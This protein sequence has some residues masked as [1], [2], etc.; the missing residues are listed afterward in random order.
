MFK[1][2]LVEDE[3]YFRKALTVSIN[4]EE[5]GC[6]VCG[7]ADDGEKALEYIEILK[8]DLILVDINLPFINGLDFIRLAKEI[9]PGLRFIIIT[10]YADFK[11]AQQA[12]DL[13][14]ECFLLKPIKEME[15]KSALLEA[16][17]SFEKEKCVAIE[18][19]YLKQKV[20]ESLPIARQKLL[21]D[22][23]DGKWLMNEQELMKKL[24]FLGID[25]KNKKFR[26]VTIEI[27]P[28][29]TCLFTQMDFQIRRAATENIVS[30]ILGYDLH[31]EKCIDSDDRIRYV[32]M[33]SSLNSIDLHF[34]I[35]ES[36]TRIC[37]SLQDNS[38]IAVS[39]GI[40][41]TYEN[42]RDIGIS[43]Q[44]SLVALKSTLLPLNNRVVFFDTVEETELNK[45]VYCCDYKS[46]LL[47]DLRTFNRTDISELIEEQL[48]PIVINSENSSLRLTC[49]QV[50]M[51]AGE[52]LLENKE[53]YESVFSRDIYGVLH[54]FDKMKT[55]TELSTLLK[56]ILDKVMDTV[57][58]KKIERSRLLVEK[59][60]NYIEE[61]YSDHDL[62]VEMVASSVY[63]NP[64][65]L[66]NLFRKYLGITIIEYLT[67]IRMLKAKE[68]FDNECSAIGN[69]AAFVGFSD[70]GYFSKTF[71]KYY[72]TSPTRYCESR[73]ELGHVK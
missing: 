15:L 47:M 62:K 72:G 53:S 7:E 16:R 29:S 64:T 52:F 43:Y 11:Y 58:T 13:G 70:A 24:E 4:W 36:C 56:H 22:L 68:L 42:I 41:N 59:A 26:V 1:V 17:N 34:R 71:K 69:I 67:N 73:S 61:H 20:K 18:L 65:Y 19:A 38:K 57:K 51:T 32:I 40:G 54:E 27:D 10:G 50:I 14:V 23:M 8:P 48:G 2:M 31:I 63:I 28:L 21:T 46:R 44:E 3:I 35:L 30:R 66:G 37:R 45:N 39:I 9:R 6:V 5:C 60:Q 33:N 49:I 25:I 12:I 55:S